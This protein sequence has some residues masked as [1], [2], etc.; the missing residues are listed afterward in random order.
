VADLSASL[1]LCFATSSRVVITFNCCFTVVVIFLENAKMLKLLS[2]FFFHIT[3]SYAIDYLI[4]HLMTNHL[5][6]RAWVCKTVAVQPF[7][8]LIVGPA[9]Y[10]VYLINS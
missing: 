10:T 7:S 8:S 6:C 4:W 1:Q 9:C 3:D 5:H 2:S